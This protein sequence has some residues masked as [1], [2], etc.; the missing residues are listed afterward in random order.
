MVLSRLTSTGIECRSAV[1]SAELQ[2]KWFST[3]TPPPIQ[4]TIMA[5]SAVTTEPVTA[6]GAG[7][8]AGVTDATNN[9]AAVAAPA[10]SAAAASTA[11]TTK[12]GTGTQ[13]DSNKWGFPVEKYSEAVKMW[14]EEGRHVLASFDD[15][16]VVVYQAFN[17]K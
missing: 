1:R 14:P 16:A 7:G 10:P 13:C 2:S 17:K 6:S 8:G 9:A 12:T 15:D 5:S 3:L 11:S 4:T